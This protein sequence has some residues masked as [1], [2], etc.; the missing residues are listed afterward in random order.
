MSD[1]VT[2]MKTLENRFMSIEK[3]MVELESI[4]NSGERI[5]TAFILNS[6]T[7]DD[8]KFIEMNK[9]IDALSNTIKNCETLLKSHET[10]N[11]KLEKQF[12]EMGHKIKHE[13]TIKMQE[14]SRIGFVEKDINN[15]QETVNKMQRQ[16]DGLVAKT[17]QT[18]GGSIMNITN[19][20][21]ELSSYIF[22]ET[23]TNIEKKNTM[24]HCKSSIHRF[25]QS[26]DSY[27]YAKQIKVV[28]H[29]THIVNLDD[30]A[31]DF[32]ARF[33]SSI[34]KN[35]VDEVIIT[36]Y[37]LDSRIVT[38]IEIIVKFKVPLAHQYINNFR[39]PINWS[40]YK[41]RNN[42]DSNDK[43]I[44]RHNNKR[45]NHGTIGSMNY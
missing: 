36:K 13:I 6:T 32:K 10:R 5:D 37:T 44:I 43:R 18:N 23:T 31:T 34:G 11:Q 2:K 15:I 33:E 17:T 12:K 30:V 14:S 3:R 24:S 8:E 28:M 40:F 1:I 19:G 42:T 25:P 27:S 29:E 20:S 39:F 4:T 26:V 21:S 7:N 22:D 38:K 9:K 35:I 16:L 41:H 45:S